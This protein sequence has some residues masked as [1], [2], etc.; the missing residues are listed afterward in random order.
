MVVTRAQEAE[1]EEAMAIAYPLEID[2]VHNF[3]NFA[4]NSRA[5]RAVSSVSRSIG[6]QV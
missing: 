6:V 4:D 1:N 3:I 2:V 5:G